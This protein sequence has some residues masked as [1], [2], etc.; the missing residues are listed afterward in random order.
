ADRTL[1]VGNDDES[2]VTTRVTRWNRTFEPQT[3]TEPVDITFEVTVVPNVT[4]DAK[5]YL[6]GNQPELGMWEP[7]IVLLTRQ[8][9]GTYKST[10]RFNAEPGTVIEFKCTRGSWETVEKGPDGS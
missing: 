9:N 2:E 7:N 8:E 1:T 3:S 5:V 6:A 4:A 10:I